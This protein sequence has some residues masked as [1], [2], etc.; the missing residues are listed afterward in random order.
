MK[1]FSTAVWQ[2][3]GKDG[4]GH[5]TSESQTLKNTPYSYNTRFENVVGTNPEELLAAAHAGCF[6][7]Q[8][9]FYLQEAGYEAD[10]LETKSTV[11]IKDFVITSSD[12]ELK[13][14]VKDISKEDFSDMVEKAKINCPVSK[15]FKANIS[16]KHTLNQQ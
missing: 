7:M 16:I 6:T 4:K 9:A 3:T 2:G 1:R 13:A 8:L 5:L 11:K 10:H 15:L 14:K 12:L